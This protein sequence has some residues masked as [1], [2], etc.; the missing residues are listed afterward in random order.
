M[1]HAKALEIDG[2]KMLLGSANLNRPSM[3]QLSELDV[4][5]QGHRALIDRLNK[6]AEDHIKN[7]EKVH[8]LDQLRYNRLRAFIES[9]L[10]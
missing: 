9:R 5:V 3:G 4:L 6:S 10:C 1:L 8:S 7:S 2:Q